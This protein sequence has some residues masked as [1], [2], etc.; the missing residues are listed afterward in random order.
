MTTAKL[1]PI[2]VLSALGLVAQVS[3]SQPRNYYTTLP[4]TCIP[5]VIYALST[6]GVVT[7]NTCNA[8]GTSYT[9]LGSGSGTL[10]T[11]G[12][13]QTVIGGTG[14]TPTA[15][16]PAGLPYG[17]WNRWGTVL[18]GG[19]Q[20]EGAFSSSAQEPTVLYENA[21]TYTPAFLGIPSGMYFRIWYTCGYSTFGICYAE[22]L[23]GGNWNLY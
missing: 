23:D 10:P 20:E 14:G 7:S 9:A 18:N 8:N 2:L 6:G 15:S 4:G 19:P 1:I 21:A 17:V 3:D 12:A 16:Y 11:L 5:G 13:G 22:S